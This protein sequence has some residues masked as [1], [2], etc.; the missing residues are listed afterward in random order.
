MVVSELAWPQ[1]YTLIV[2]LP[3]RLSEAIMQGSQ[4]Q[5]PV[6]Q[7][8]DRSFWESGLISYVVNP[9]LITFVAI[10]NHGYTLI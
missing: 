8:A 7:R 3:A 5:R 9:I 1:R 6:G 4:R 2:Y 10:K